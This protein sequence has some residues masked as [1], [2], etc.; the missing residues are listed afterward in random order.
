MSYKMESLQ[1]SQ[2]SGKEKTRSE[3]EITEAKKLNSC[4]LLHDAVNGY[5]I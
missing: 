1:N 4:G 2:E 3:N 5:T